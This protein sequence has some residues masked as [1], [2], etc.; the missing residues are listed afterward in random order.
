MQK[1]GRLTIKKIGPFCLF[2]KLKSIYFVLLYHVFKKMKLTQII[3][4]Q[5]VNYHLYSTSMDNLITEKQ[6]DEELV[7]YH[8]L[9]I[10][11][12]FSTIYMIK[13]TFTFVIISELVKIFNKIFCMSL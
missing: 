11:C 9:V 5:L 8:L 7:N 10:F 1:I 13:T 4:E 6:K 2:K 3:D 12:I